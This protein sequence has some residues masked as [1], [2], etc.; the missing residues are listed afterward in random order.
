MRFHPLSQLVASPARV[1]RERYEPTSPD[2]IS[3]EKHYESYDDM[4]G[5]EVFAGKTKKL[6]QFP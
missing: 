1:Q 3:Y 6:D 5:M 4:E 2:K